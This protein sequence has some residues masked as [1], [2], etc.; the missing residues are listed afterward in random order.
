MTATLVSQDGFD[1]T[2]QSTGAR[3]AHIYS[4]QLK[5]QSDIKVSKAN[6][7][8]VVETSEVIKPLT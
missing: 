2:L 1:E 7:Y 6:G 5:L 3:R 8:F 4:C